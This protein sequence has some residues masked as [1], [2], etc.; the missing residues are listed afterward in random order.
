MVYVKIQVRVSQVQPTTMAK[1]EIITPVY[2]S[3]LMLCTS[4]IPED[5]GIG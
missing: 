2:T 1:M 3:I 5:T 4:Q